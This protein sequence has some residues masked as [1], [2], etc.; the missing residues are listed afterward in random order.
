MDGQNQ[1]FLSGKCFGHPANSE[2]QVRMIMV[3]ESTSKDI[4][5]VLQSEC[6]SSYT[7]IQTRESRA[8]LLRLL[9]SPEDFLRHI[10]L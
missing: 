5:P 8:L 1:D 4:P 10:R 2:I 7:H 9:Q 6:C 3:L